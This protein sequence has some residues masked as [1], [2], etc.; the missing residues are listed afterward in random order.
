M[1]MFGYFGAHENLMLH[2]GTDHTSFGALMFEALLDGFLLSLFVFPILYLFV[3]KSLSQKNK[4]L[5]NSEACLEERVEHRTRQLNDTINRLNRRQSEI[6]TLNEMIQQFQTC[7]TVD[8]AFKVVEEQLKDAFPSVS[9]SVFLIKSNHK[10]PDLAAVWGS[11]DTQ[12]SCLP[13]KDCKS[14]ICEKPKVVQSDEGLSQPICSQLADLPKQWHI[15]L[16]LM[17]KTTTIGTLHLTAPFD[18]TGSETGEDVDR[19]GL[20]W[21]TLAESLAMEISNIRLREGLENQA[22][23]DHLTGLYN[24]RYLD[25]VLDKELH[26]VDRSGQNLSVFMI[27]IDHFKRYNDTYGH[28]GGDAVLKT[29]GDLLNHWVR[30]EDVVART[31]GEEFVMVLPGANSD[32]ALRRANDLRKTIEELDIIHEGQKLGRVTV[33]IGIAVYQD[34]ALDKDGLM[35]AA[36]KAMYVSKREGR[37]R[38]TLAHPPALPAAASL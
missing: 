24:R 19:R 2:F 34:H 30:E 15:C 25:D 14:F 5:V 13:N 8:D 3:F 28:D 31:G 32:A 12:N 17:V 26:R 1:M 20:F 11:D 4:A 29:I 9:G 33:S 35:Q 6:F 22:L 36:D 27:D 7:D 38:V 37:N 23:K 21:G 10:S 16:P 18:P